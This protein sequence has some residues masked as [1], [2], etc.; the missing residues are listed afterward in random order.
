MTTYNRGQYIEEAIESV[1]KSLYVHWEL[2]IT[3]DCSTDATTELVHKYLDD[4]RIKY[5]KND[6]NLGQFA[7][8]NKAASLA[9]GKY[10]KYLDSDD[11]IYAFGLDILVEGLE[12][13]PSAAIAIAS[14]DTHP[15][16]FKYPKLVRS[17]DAYK[18]YFFNDA[19][20]T[21]GP[22]GTMFRKDA[23]DAVKGYSGTHA[24]ADTELMLKLAA[25]YD[26]VRVQ[27]SFFFYR[28]HGEQVLNQSEKIEIYAI[29]AYKNGVLALYDSKCP[30]NDN[31]R[32]KAYSIMRKK[33]VKIGLYQ[34]IKKGKIKLG[35]SIIK[36][37]L[38]R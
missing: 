13:Y 12:L 38:K 6:H 32:D 11:L 19:L 7:N 4:K 22:T 23:F 2:I 37:L 5:F 21:I 9:N 36:H 1:Q 15:T 31:D 10:I 29:E 30:L 34:I 27:P 16:E 8:R 18:T 20:L 24:T 25:L 14:Q 3:D 33:I 26:V 28:I 17:E 35:F